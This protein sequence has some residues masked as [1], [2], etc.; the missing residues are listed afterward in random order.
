MRNHRGKPVSVGRL[1]SLLKQSVARA[2]P[3]VLVSGEVVDP[4]LSQRGHLYFRLRDSQAELK[5]VM[6]KRDVQRLR[7]PLR[8]GVEVTVRGGLDV[9]P[10]RGDLQLVVAALMP[11]GQGQKA[12][13]LKALREKLK[14]EGVFDR[15]RRPLPP[16]PTKVG[17]VTSLS[18]AV[19]HDVYQ[20]VQSRFP[21]AQLI[22]SPSAV[23]GDKAACELSEALHRLRDRV[24]VVIIARGGGS[25]EELL[26]FSD[27]SLVRQVAAFPQPVVAAIGH[28]SDSTLLD[29]VADHTAPTPTAAA[30]LVTPDRTELSAEVAACVDRLKRAQAQGLH[31]RR[32]E[33]ARSAAQCRAH[34]PQSRFERQKDVFLRWEQRL[35][36]VL[37]QRL[38]E[39]RVRLDNQTRRLHTQLHALARSPHRLHLKELSSRLSPALRTLSSQRRTQLDGY[40][41]RLEA[42][43]PRRLLDRGFVLVSNEQGLVTSSSGRTQGE[44]LELLFAD[45]R[46]VVEIKRIEPT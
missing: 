40:R 42:V 15:E 46:L 26:P 34:H 20:S 25:F 3:S 37:V 14:V 23:S 30:V 22:L 11:S 7:E 45:G 29:L 12:L 24:E 8:P 4:V 44:E 17:L 33:L 43:G 9:Y 27:E 10:A 21:C 13:Q 18:S 1:L 2:F 28:G 16:I 19:L 41:K 39:H 6:W 38:R 32:A 36:D 5:A 35:G 31:L